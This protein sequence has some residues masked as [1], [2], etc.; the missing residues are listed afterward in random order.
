[1]K[2]DKFL[3]IEK[4]EMGNTPSG[5]SQAFRSDYWTGW[6]NVREK[7]YST[8][9]QS[10]QYVGQK[11]THF[12]IR[13]NLLTEGINTTMF[14]IYRNEEYLIKDIIEIDPFHLSITAVIRERN[15]VQSP[16]S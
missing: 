14:V 15:T 11:A 9:T 7:N 2:L 10:G 4:E 5:G 12:T 8:V 1:M 13:K 16:P 6:G 3:R